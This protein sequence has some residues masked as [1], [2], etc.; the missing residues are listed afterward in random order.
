MKSMLPTFWTL[1]PLFL[2]GAAA[3]GGIALINSVANLGGLLGPRD[4]RQREDETGSFTIG[5]FIMAAT[6]FLG[7]LLALTVR[8]RGQGESRMQRVVAEVYSCR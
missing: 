6:L 7:G 4:H 2:T 3:A 5:Y 1:P 8:H